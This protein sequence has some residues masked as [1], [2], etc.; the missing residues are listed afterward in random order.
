MRL[1]LIGCQV[2]TRELELVATLVLAESPPDIEVF[3]A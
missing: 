3:Q 2:L 1:K